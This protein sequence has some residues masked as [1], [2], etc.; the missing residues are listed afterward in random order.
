MT[1][2][3]ADNLHA[4]KDIVAES[5]QIKFVT[6]IAVVVGLFQITAFLGGGVL[7]FWKVPLWVNSV[8][9]FQVKTN[10][11]LT[12]IATLNLR[13][14]EYMRRHDIYTTEV[15]GLEIKEGYP[16]EGLKALKSIREIITAP[17]AVTA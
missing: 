9:Q 2:S 14:L 8:E 16:V 15:T 6:I 7:L 1:E 3:N 11:T 12:E 13:F 10:A 17:K 5:R 4:M